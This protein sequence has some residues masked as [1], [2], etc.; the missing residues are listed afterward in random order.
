V[1]GLTLA[2]VTAAGANAATQRELA[3]GSH[4]GQSHTSHKTHPVTTKVETAPAVTSRVIYID[5]PTVPNPAPYVDPNECQDSSTN[6]TVAQAC[7]YWGEC[8]APT[9]AQATNPAANNPM[10]A[11]D[12][13]PTN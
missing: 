11:P 5:V 8:G 3:L 12:P 10:Y 4:G 1:T 2:L 7:D 13:T 9:Y 6:C